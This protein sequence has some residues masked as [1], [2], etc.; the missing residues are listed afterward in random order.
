MQQNQHTVTNQLLYNKNDFDDHQPAQGTVS[1]KFAP[2]PGPNSLQACKP[3]TL[4]V[5]L[6]SHQR[7]TARYKYPP[8]G[9]YQYQNTA[10]SSHRHP[11]TSSKHLPVAAASP[12]TYPQHHIAFS[13][14]NHA[15]LGDSS[16]AG[17]DPR[18]VNLNTAKDYFTNPSSGIVVFAT[19]GTHTVMQ[20]AE[21]L[22]ARTALSIRS[23]S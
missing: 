5:H 20:K 8:R 1:S 13:N 17:R 9:R 16:S 7:T 23:H 12:K 15:I 6:K 3:N 19:E 18:S 4:P 14:Y 10:R 22:C 2:L 21:P 11:S